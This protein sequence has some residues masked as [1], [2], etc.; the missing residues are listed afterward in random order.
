[1]RNRNMTSQSTDSTQVSTATTL[2]H[3]VS[4]WARDILWSYSLACWQSDS[5]TINTQKESTVTFTF[6]WLGTFS[7]RCPLQTVLTSATAA[8]TTDVFN[9]LLVNFSCTISLFK[10]SPSLPKSSFCKLI[11]NVRCLPAGIL[12]PEAWP[13]TLSDWGTNSLQQMFI[14]IQPNTVRPMNRPVDWLFS[15]PHGERPSDPNSADF[16]RCVN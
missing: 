3:L 6:I 7:N 10:Q 15:G 14:W 12:E 2:V 1:M 16:Q 13:F 9:P 4:P 8:E 11:H 5:E